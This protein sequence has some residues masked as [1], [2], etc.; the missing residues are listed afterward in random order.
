[1]SENKEVKE[2]YDK[3]NEMIDD[4]EVRRAAFKTQL[5]IMEKYEAKKDGIR[6]VANKMLDA[7]EPIDKIIQFTDLTKEEIEKLKNPI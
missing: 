5:D 4:V 2:A 6:E 3:Y 1:M 7:N